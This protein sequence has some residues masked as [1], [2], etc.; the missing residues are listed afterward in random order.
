MLKR[1][2]TEGKLSDAREHNDRNGN[3]EIAN[4]SPNHIV[5]EEGRVPECSERNGKEG[6]TKTEDKRKKGHF[7]VTV[8]L[9]KS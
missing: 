9:V 6:S 2:V 1:N 3:G 7:Q 5:A 8:R 4:G